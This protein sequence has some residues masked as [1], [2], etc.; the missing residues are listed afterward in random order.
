M[1]PRLLSPCNYYCGN[2]AIYR[3]N[4]CSGCDEATEK[5]KLRGRSFVAYQFATERGG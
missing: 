2:C 1:D 5:A 4:L 3:R